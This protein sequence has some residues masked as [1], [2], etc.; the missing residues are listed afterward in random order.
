MTVPSSCGVC[1]ADPRGVEPCLRCAILWLLSPELEEWSVC[2]STPDDFCRAW[3]TFVERTRADLASRA[4]CV[5]CGFLT[6]QLR[7]GVPLCAGCR[8][9]IQAPGVLP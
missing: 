5:S 7:A 9:R 1:G 8:S 3:S 6:K 2:G 4:P